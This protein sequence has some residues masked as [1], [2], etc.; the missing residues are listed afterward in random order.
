MSSNSLRAALLAIACLS[1][2]PL[3]AQEACVSAHADAQLL[4]MRGTLLDAREKLLTC[5]QS[6]C[7]KLISK[8][9]TVWL[10]EVEASLGSVVF[11][12]T[13]ERGHDLVEVAIR[14]NGQAL[15]RRAD[16][17]AITLDPGTY[18][19]RF[20]A[21]GFAPENLSVTVRTSE[22]NRIV[23]VQLQRPAPAAAHGPV[24]EAG[25]VPALS[26]VF[27]AVGLAGFGAFAGFGLAGKHEYN[28]LKD[29]CAPTCSRDE[30]AGGKRL[31]VLANVGLG[32]GIAGTVAA[33]ASYFL[34]REPAR[35][36]VGLQAGLLER[37]A[38]LGY[39]GRY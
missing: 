2:A 34:L 1:A 12:V 25:G 28:S 27:G 4:R 13:D 21:S 3:R 26:Y 7:P 18:E 24:D 6:E 22:K 33:V 19:F 20:D 14:G 11:A 17:R 39:S 8:D 36:G 32:L 37:G 16:G 35:S 9:C 30:R 10:G 23:R 15:A 5:A 31:Y 38:Y 29:S